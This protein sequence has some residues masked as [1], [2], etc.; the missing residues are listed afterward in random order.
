MK[1]SPTRQR[2]TNHLTPSFKCR[3][4]CFLAYA[5]GYLKWLSMVAISQRLPRRHGG[6]VPARNSYA[7]SEFTRKSEFPSNKSKGKAFHNAKRKTS[8]LSLKTP[9]RRCVWR[10]GLG[11]RDQND[12]NFPIFEGPV[13]PPVPARLSLSEKRNIHSRNRHQHKTA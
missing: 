8:D 1:G 3:A 2:G 4:T 5:S 10:C 11:E 6:F 7:K 12:A 9:V 13:V